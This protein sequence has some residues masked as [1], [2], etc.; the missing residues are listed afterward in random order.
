MPPEKLADLERLAALFER[1]LLSRGEFEQE[2]RR[3]LN[4]AGAA[5]PSSA[6]HSVAAPMA[7]PDDIELDLDE[8]SKPRPPAIG[9]TPRRSTPSRP[10]DSTS[11][12]PTPAATPASRPGELF[13]LRPPILLGGCITLI[14]LGGAAT[15]I[16]SL[17]GLSAGLVLSNYNEPE[18]SSDTVPS[19][20]A[21]AGIES[22]QSPPR[23][24]EAKP[25]PSAPS[26][27]PAAAKPAAAK[28]QSEPPAKG[29]PHA[30][31]F[32]PSDCVLVEAADG[33]S[34][35]LSRYCDALDWSRCEESEW[36]DAKCPADIEER[37]A[38]GR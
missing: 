38:K 36:P 20:P 32:E 1:G 22:G 23:A 6:P 37:P 8:A 27:K 7:D 14:I 10:P 5:A 33:R 13:G 15:A 34:R 17:L 21:G 12:G 28:P 29:V 11:G 18:P 25:A 31:K 9:E 19:A 4:G 24:S 16:A 35:E 26:A 3:L 2:K 30:D